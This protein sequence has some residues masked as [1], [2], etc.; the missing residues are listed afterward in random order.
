MQSQATS[1]G[2]YISAPC[3]KILANR[4][5][6]TGS[7]GVTMGSLMDIS[8]LLEN[9]GIRVNTIT[10]GSN[11]AMGS[12]MEPMT[13]EQRAI[14]QALVD[15]AYEQFVELVAEGRDMSV[16]EVTKLA[17][18]R[19]Y[20]NYQALDSGLID[21]VEDYETAYE[22]MEEV[23]GAEGYYN[24]LYYPTL[25]EEM[26]ASVQ[27]IVPKSDMAAVSELVNSPLNGV[28]LYMYT[29]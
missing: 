9:L 18:G 14:F 16:A 5:C 24:Q 15:E 22:Y 29:K 2:Y 3:D 17:D 12:G 21:N 7:I 8:E 4:N 25:W 20:S 27:T 26:F 19:I 10:A 11:K 6:W 1:G 13:P 28:P 23:C